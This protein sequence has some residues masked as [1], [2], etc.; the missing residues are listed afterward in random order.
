MSSRSL[1]GRPRR[2]LDFHRQKHPE[3]GSLPADDGL[4]SEEDQ[5]GT[6]VWPPPFQ[7]HPEQA[8]FSPQSGLVHLS[9]EHR[10]LVAECEVFHDEIML[11]MEPAQQVA[12][13][14]QNNR[15]HG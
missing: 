6:P 4:R 11:G 3:S 15:E 2:C 14:R 8:V 1:P 9:T 10:D 12:Q 7:D 5:A 13:E